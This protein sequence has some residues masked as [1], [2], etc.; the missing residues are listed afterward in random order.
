MS[1][2]DDLKLTSDMRTEQYNTSKL[3]IKYSEL[4]YRTKLELAKIEIELDVAVN[5]HVA[6]YTGNMSRECYIAKPLRKIL[7]RRDAE[8]LANV[9]DDVAAIRYKLAKCITDVE[10]YKD[11]LKHISERTFAI[12]N[13]LEYTKITT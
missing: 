12:K 5:K 6:Y 11:V 9:Q 2:F 13:I 1:N 8:K 4:Q 10:L 7:E 3:F